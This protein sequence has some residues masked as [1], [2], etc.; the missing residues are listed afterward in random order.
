VRALQACTLY[1]D[2]SI[3]ATNGLSTSYLLPTPLKKGN[4]KAPQNSTLALAEAGISPCKSYVRSGSADIAIIKAVSSVFTLQRCCWKP[5]LRLNFLWISLR[6]TQRAQF[7]R[8]WNLLYRWRVCDYPLVLDRQ[9][10]AEVLVTL[11]KTP[12]M[13]TTSENYAAYQASQLYRQFYCGGNSYFLIRPFLTVKL[14]WWL[15]SGGSIGEMTL[16]RVQHRF[17]VITGE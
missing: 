15:K 14:S 12:R 2:T 11:R 9:N 8:N 10:L 7:E 3:S 13:S 1:I 5:R 17:I 6:G 4:K 16:T